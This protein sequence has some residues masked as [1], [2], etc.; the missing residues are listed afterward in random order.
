MTVITM[1]RTELSRLR[2]M[3]DLADGRTRVEAAAALMGLQRR[4]VYRLLDAFRAQ[5]PDALISKRRGKPSNRAHGAAFRQTCLAIVRER[6]EDFGPTLA[7]EKLAEVH[8]LP[9]GVET[10]RQ[11]MIDDGIWVR[12]RDRIKRVHQPRHRRDCLGE[13]VQ[14]DGCEHWWFE[15]RGPQCTLLVFVDDATSRL[16][17]LSFVASE[18]AFSYFRATRTYLEDHGKPIALYSDK[19]SVF[20]TNKPEQAEGGMTQFGRALHELN[21]DILCANAPQAKGRV[22][23]AHKTLQDRLVKELR[24]AGVNDIDAGNALL[25]GFMAD[26]N[27]RFAKPAR[28]DKDLHRPLA[29]HDDLDGSF[30]WRVERTV[31]NSLT[32][33]Y[34]RVMFILE[35]NDITRALPRK[36]VTVYDFPDGRI[37]VRHQGLALPYRTFDRI[38][39]VDQ[40]AIVENKRLSEALEMCRAMQAELPPK[41]RSKKAPARTSQQRH[42][43]GTGEGEPSYLR[44]G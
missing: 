10:L 26:Y 12:R 6:Y 11:W 44:L 40:G 8:G 13:L 24:L 20:R 30:A 18:S 38:T 1:S 42:M 41:L 22:E 28:N 2:V 23:R 16:M 21:I 4:Q 32:V 37:E 34:D 36:K 39:R 35:P 29:P 9:I 31:T 25:P 19:H 43:F 14:V 33:Q 5:G 15:N 17:H 3:I 27:R 7:A